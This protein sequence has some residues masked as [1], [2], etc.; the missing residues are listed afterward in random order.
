MSQRNHPANQAECVGVCTCERERESE[1][2][3]GREERGYSSTQPMMLIIFLQ[4][5]PI[6]CSCSKMEGALQCT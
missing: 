6:Q 2:E 4:M 5:P 1:R 3:K